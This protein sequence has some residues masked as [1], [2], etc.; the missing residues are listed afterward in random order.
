M[1][2]L[3]L[4]IGCTPKAQPRIKAR[5]VQSRGG[6]A[7][8]H[9]YTPSTANAF[10]DEILLRTRA[11]PDF[12]PEPWTGPVRLDV[13][14]FFERPQYMHHKK[15]PD[16]HIPHTA[17]PD[18]DNIDKAVMDAL[19]ASGLFKDDAQVCA[20][21]ITKWYVDRECQPGVR[22]KAQQIKEDSC[23]H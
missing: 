7:F 11:H 17:K 12:P 15:F 20:G 10:K 23:S 14:V 2:I 8:A 13:E 18:R 5:V 21:E 22:I 3:E 16:G 4:A 19:T 9:I 1:S 6:K